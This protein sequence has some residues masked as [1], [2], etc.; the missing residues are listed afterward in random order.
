MSQKKISGYTI[1]LEQLLGK[2]SYGAVFIF[3][4]RYTKVLKMAQTFPSQ[5]K[6]LKKKI[7]DWIFIVVDSD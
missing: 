5:S 4:F 1:F 3:L 6:L 7:V 2:G